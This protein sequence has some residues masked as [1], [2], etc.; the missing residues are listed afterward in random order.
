MEHSHIMGGSSAAQRINCPGS[1][2]LEQDSPP[3]PESVYALQGTVLHSAME[4]LLVHNPAD[5]Y[6]AEA[7]L[8]DLEGKDLGFGDE[9]AITHEL[10]EVKLRPALLAWMDVRDRYGLNDWFIESRVS[11]EVL[12]DGA[13]G[14]S[15]FIA[16]DRNGNL[17]IL[18]W[19]F[20]DGV[21]VTAEANYGLSFYAGATLYDPE[22]ELKEFRAEMLSDEPTIYFHI[23]QP[24]R[25]DD[26][27]LDTW[28][29]D[30]GYIEN[31]LDRAVAAMDTARRANAPVKA[32]SWCRWCRAKAICPA[33]K[34]LVIEATSTEPRSMSG[35]ELAKRLELADLLKAWITE[36]Y[37]LAKIEMEGGAAI[38]G[39][40]LVNKLPRRHWIDDKQAEKVLRSNRVKAADLWQKKLISPAQ[41]EKLDSKLYRK[42]AD[43]N[44]ESKS[45]GV[46]VVPDTDKRPAISS[47]NELLA[48]AM[49]NAGL[50]ETEK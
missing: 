25:G 41:L 26:E 9:W 24:R 3:K 34:G 15:D 38:P 22:P 19:K 48:I 40:K 28:A 14:T 31:F 8:R 1:F 44:V 4:L 18:D 43:K 20:G 39:F 29:T 10:I 16:S 46:T 11:L 17:H 33:Q 5:D 27:V 30:T 37:E 35:V 23:I 21:V 6:T 50:I 36:V 47:S 2:Q 7:L 49:Q 45:S 42:I 13:F 12:V 32:G